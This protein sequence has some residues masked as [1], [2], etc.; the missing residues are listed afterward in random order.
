VGNF[1]ANSKLGISKARQEK[2]KARHVQS[3]EIPRLGKATCA[4][5]GKEKAGQGKKKL[6]NF[7]N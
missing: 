2:C 3:S 6:N 5:R 1:E 7:T 4:R